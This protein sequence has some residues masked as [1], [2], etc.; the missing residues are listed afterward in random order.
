MSLHKSILLSLCACTTLQAAE[1]PNGM[2]PA[3]IAA[4]FAGG[5]TLLQGLPDD[6]P[7]ITLPPGLD[8]R[9]VGTHQRSQY[10]QTILLRSTHGI[11]D[12][13]NRLLAAVTAQGWQE[14]TSPT[15]SVGA[16]GYLQLC[17][18]T[19]GSLTV[20]MSLSATDA[21][22]HVQVQRTVYPVQVT[23]PS[24][25]V[26]QASTEQSA[27]RYEFL[28][29]LAPVL[30]VPEG[31]LSPRPGI[32]IRGVSYSGSNYR[33]DREGLI[34][35][36]GMTLR[37]VNAHFTEQLAA[38]GWVIDSDAVGESS[39]ISTWT[40][41][42]TFPGADSPEQPI[43]ILTVLPGS[44][45]DSYGIVLTLRSAPSSGTGLITDIPSGFAPV[46]INP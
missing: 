41:T 32:G 7:P 27:A 21:L 15:L 46:R 9:V 40:R 37:T 44:G 3:D 16:E 17:N 23:L 10:Q 6:F 8:L 45:E 28:N 5:G 20:R 29:S 36:P 30:E 4:E 25:A 26:Q 19:Y 11:D 43:L 24:C 22:T 13:K 35:V 38:Q 42:V 1:F 31:T 33:I 18:D 12:L 14:L 39:A 2:V 34:D